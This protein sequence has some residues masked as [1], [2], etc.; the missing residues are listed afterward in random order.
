MGEV[1]PDIGALAPPPGSMYGLSEGLSPISLSLPARGRVDP[2]D[3]GELSH[4]RLQD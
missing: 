4:L 1:G 3:V 2:V